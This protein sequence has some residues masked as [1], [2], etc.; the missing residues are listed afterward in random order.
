M[1]AYTDQIGN[2]VTLDAVPRRIISLVPSQSELLFDMGL[3][4]ELVGITKFC[5]HPKELKLTKT[6]VGGTKTLHLDKIEALNP[7]LIIANKEE[8]EERLV[9]ELM[10][11]YPVWTSDIHKLADAF[12]MITE[13]GKITDRTEKAS[14]IVTEIKAAFKT[15]QSERS[16][17]ILTA[18]YFI[19]CDPFMTAGGSS[20]ISHMLDVCGLE[21]VFKDATLAYPEYSADELRAYS[22]DL[23]LLS[24][25]PF[26]FTEKHIQGFKNLFPG[27]R[28]LLVD[29]EMFSWYG[30]R[31]CK[32][33]AYFRQLFGDN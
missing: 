27:S 14:E 26:P 28:I 25:E 4:T 31:L 29:G 16:K 23:I 8:N 5:V 22:P 30:S 33:P 1:N 13:L 9:K 20:F 18:A 32:S 10:S 21:N 12:E 3:A 6:V 19:W 7:D 17:K 2:V 11:R 15:F 24:S